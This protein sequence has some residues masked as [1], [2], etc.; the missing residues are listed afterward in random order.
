MS[1]TRRRLQKGETLTG[2]LVGLSL[3]LV[4][5]AGG[6]A[7]LANQLRGHRQALHDTHLHHD[8]RSAMDWM[9]KEL[10]QAQYSAKAWETRSPSRC[11]DTF[12]KDAQDFSLSGPAL[13]FSYDRN[14][15][16]LRDKDEC[17]GFRLAAQTIHIK[18]S[19]EHAGDWQAITDT[20]S[21]KVSAL[22]WTLHCS[23]VQGWLRRSV[24]MTLSA[25]WP[26]DPSRQISL[27]QTVRLQ[28]DLPA[29]VQT[30][31]CP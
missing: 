19:C 6:S 12:C 7:M 10:S 2:L 5:L 8:L 24:E 15:N 25:A 11:L 18:R 17:M 22:Q 16:G 4:V 23:V 21:L 9:A 14:H 1:T 31:F 29:S 30:Q 28:N 20:G 3:G 27:R 13:V 26:H